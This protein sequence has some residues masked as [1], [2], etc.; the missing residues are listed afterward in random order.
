MKEQN[1]KY[2]LD[3]TERMVGK[4]I[5]SGMRKRSV[6]HPVDPYE[7]YI[8]LAPQ[9][10]AKIKKMNSGTLGGICGY[11]N[12]YVN[13]GWDTNTNGFIFRTTIDDVHLL[14]DF[15]S[16]QSGRDLIEEIATAVIISTAC[17]IIIQDQLYM[18][19]VEWQMD[20]ACRG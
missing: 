5:L 1:K 19:R 20:K 12:L 4:N 10:R 11:G 9:V 18:D 15:S 7:L 6:N 14:N 16:G 3:V 8:S 17:D 2:I 13:E